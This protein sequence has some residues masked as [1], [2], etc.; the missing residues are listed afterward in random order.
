MKVR[1]WHPSEVLNPSSAVILIGRRGSGKTTA[2]ADLAY[3]IWRQ[4]HIDLAIGMSPTDETNESMQQFIPRSLIFD[5]YREDVISNLLTVQRNMWKKKKG[6]NVALFLD[7]CA[8]KKSIFKSETIRELFMNGRHRHITVVVTLQYSIDMPPAIRNQA[9]AV[10]QCR[11]TQISSR[12]TLHKQFFGAIKSFK[13]FSKVMDGCT[14]NYKMM[15]LH[16]GGVVSNNVEDNIFWWRANLHNEE[17]LL[18]RPCFWSMPML[19]RCNTKMTKT[20]YVRTT[21]TRV[22]DESSRRE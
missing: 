12:E 9:D 11:D 17:F 21:T 6:Y 19:P 20:S 13:D 3:N 16:N 10:I 8:Y 2:M 18:G 7:D 14:E 5:S 1:R 4:G 15:V 22:V